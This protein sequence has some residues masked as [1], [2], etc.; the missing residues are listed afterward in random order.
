MSAEL[1]AVWRVDEFESLLSPRPNFLNDTL[2]DVT[3]PTIA[4]L[5]RKSMDPSHSQIQIQIVDPSHISTLI[6]TRAR[7]L[8]PPH[9]HSTW[10]ILPQPS[11]MQGLPC[12]LTQ[13]PLPCAFNVS[14][15]ERV[16]LLIFILTV[17][18]NWSLPCHH[19]DPSK[20]AYRQAYTTRLTTSASIMS[21]FASTASPPMPV[22]PPPLV[23]VGPRLSRE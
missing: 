7:F 5:Y 20:P 2:L 22:R 19:L 21:G 13:Y 9:L 23:I 6:I 1:E 8:S 3:S 17:H 18:L 11:Y 10:N 14:R 15:R 4:L 16:F 12:K